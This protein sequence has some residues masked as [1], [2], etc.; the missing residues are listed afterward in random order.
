MTYK[1][2][3]GFKRRVKCSVCKKAFYPK[4]VNKMFCPKCDKVAKGL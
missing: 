1:K 3:E 2:I 4:S